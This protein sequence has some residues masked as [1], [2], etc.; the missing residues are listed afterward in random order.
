L[1]TAVVVSINSRAFYIT[2][3]SAGLVI[4]FEINF[5]II[6]LNGTEERDKCS[7]CDE[8]LQTVKF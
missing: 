8:G 6:L 1:L 7:R 4:A 5:P 3:N 2:G